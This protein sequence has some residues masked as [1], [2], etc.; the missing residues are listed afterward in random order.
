MSS[1]YVQISNETTNVMKDTQDLLQKAQETVNDMQNN[2][3][4]TIEELQKQNEKLNDVQETV[5]NTQEETKFV[6][7]VLNNLKKESN[8]TKLVMTGACVGV[9]AIAGLIIQRFRK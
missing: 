5:S 3:T 1:S 2:T 6:Q 8:K 9:V 7:K 4:E